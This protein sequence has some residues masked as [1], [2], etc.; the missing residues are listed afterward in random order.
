MSNNYGDLGVSA[1]VYAEK[2]MLEHAEPILV[3]NKLGDHKPMPKNASKVI[4]FR[5]P[6]PLPIVTTP[7]AEGVR[8]TGSNFRYDRF[9]ATLNQYGDWMPITDVVHDLHE[10]PVGSD[11]ARMAGEQAAETVEMVAFGELIGGTNVIYANGSARNAVNTP[12]TLVHVRNASRVLLAARAK[13]ITSILSGS[14]MINTTPVEAAFVAVCHTDII[15][16]VRNMKGFTPVAEYGSRKALCAEEVGSVEDIRFIASPLFN[17][18]VN[19]GGA[20]GS[21][22]TEAI[23]TGGTTADVYPVLVMGQ[24]AFGHIALKGNKEAGGAIKPMVRNPGTPSHGDELGQN[25]SVSWKTF[26][27]CK[28]LNDLW[29]VRI[30]VAALKTPEA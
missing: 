11:M 2:K 9:N 30:E 21:G 5:R 18:W 7:I 26:Y 8:P 3:L 27:T 15:A 28:I 25:G 1:G 22:A 14:V 17:S 19:A 23:S 24:H 13:K 16:S 12:L 10:D 4:R 6:I 29:M 20:K